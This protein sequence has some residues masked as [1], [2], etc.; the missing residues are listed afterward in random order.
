MTVSFEMIR[1]EL[2][3]IEKTGNIGH[4]ISNNCTGF[5]VSSRHS[6]S[7]HLLHSQSKGGMLTKH[8]MP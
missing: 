7:K 8:F 5:L 6:R 2:F 4:Q 1:Q 3:L